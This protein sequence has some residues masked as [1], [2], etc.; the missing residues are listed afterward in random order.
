MAEVNGTHKHS[1]YIK[2]KS[3]EILYLMSNIKVSATQDGWLAY[4]S[5]GQPGSQAQLTIYRDPDITHINWK[6]H[7]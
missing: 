3:A 6:D 5:A 7:T 2:K 4:Q 1:R